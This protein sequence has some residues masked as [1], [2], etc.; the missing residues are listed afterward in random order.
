MADRSTMTVRRRTFS[1]EDQEKLFEETLLQWK[2]LGQAA[3]WQA[4][5][6]MLDWW[7]MVRGLE[8]ETQWVG[9]PLS[10]AYGRL[11]RELESDWTVPELVG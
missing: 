1:P 6:D 3:A 4:I 2:S 8:P 10:E 7:F 5:Y 11:R 9:Q